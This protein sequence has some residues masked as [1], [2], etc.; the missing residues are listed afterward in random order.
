MTIKKRMSIGLPPTI[1]WEEETG[2]VYF[3]TNITSIQDSDEPCYIYDE[4]RCTTKEFFNTYFEQLRADIDYL[5]MISEVD[6]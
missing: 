1:E 2:Y 3:R 4:H 6:L 5:S